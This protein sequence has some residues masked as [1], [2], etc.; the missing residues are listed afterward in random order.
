MNPDE[1]DLDAVLT[2]EQRAGLARRQRQALGGGLQLAGALVLL[3]TVW[4]WWGFGVALALAA[5]CAIAVGFL[6]ER[7]GLR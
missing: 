5:A 3:V 2:P 6:L 4:A 7:D 1:L